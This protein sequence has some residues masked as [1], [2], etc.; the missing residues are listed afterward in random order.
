MYNSFHIL[1]SSA[2]GYWGESETSYIGRRLQETFFCF[3]FIFGRFSG[4]FCSMQTV[5][6]LGWTRFGLMF[7]EW[8][9]ALIIFSVGSAA[10]DEWQQADEVID[11]SPNLRDLQFTAPVSAFL[12]S[13][14]VIGFVILTGML[15]MFC[16]TFCSDKGLSAS[17]ELICQGVLA[18][19]FWFVGGIVAV[20]RLNPPEF[21]DDTFSDADVRYPRRP[22]SRT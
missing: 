14:A 1:A 15:A 21:T 11:N 9:F 13:W 12:I 2:R 16:M 6:G 19:V 18:W 20:V 8:V 3:E 10:Y 22:F 17:V 4:A 7:L 5:G